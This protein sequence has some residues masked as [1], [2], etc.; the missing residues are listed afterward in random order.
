MVG[1]VLCL[2]YSVLVGFS[3]AWVFLFAL[4]GSGFSEN[5]TKTKFTKLLH[6]IV[7]TPV[8]GDQP[9]RPSL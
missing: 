8:Q 7:I 6:L 5:G 2:L 9:W 1:V 3:F 4:V